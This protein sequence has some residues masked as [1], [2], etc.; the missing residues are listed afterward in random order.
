[1]PLPFNIPRPPNRSNPNQDENG[2]YDG[3]TNPYVGGYRTRGTR[4]GSSDADSDAD[5]VARSSPIPP[6]T[7][8][9]SVGVD[10]VL[11]DE[12]NDEMVNRIFHQH[13]FDDYTQ[14]KYNIEFSLLGGTQQVNT[15]VD[16]L[17]RISER[18]F[19]ASSDT[20][21]ADE[22]YGDRQPEVQFFIKSLNF[23]TINSLSIANPET[24]NTAMFNMEIE[25]PYGFS[26]DKMIRRAANDLGYSS[27]WPANRFIF[28]LD[29]WFSGYRKNGEFVERIPVI[30]PYPVIN[31]NRESQGIPPISPEL[32][33]STDYTETYT[34]SGQY[35]TEEKFTFF[36][37]V[38][39]IE[40]E[41]SNGT[42][43]NYKL[44][45]LPVQDIAMYPEYDTLNY[46][47]LGIGAQTGNNTFGEYIDEMT[48]YLNNFYEWYPSIDEGR[49]QSANPVPLRT[50]EFVIP[51]ELRN[52]TFDFL[53][54]TNNDEEAAAVTRLGSQG[55]SIRADIS[56]KI[57]FTEVGRSS[58]ISR[59]YPKEIYTVR[60]RIDYRGSTDKHMGYWGDLT[61]I[62]VV[63][64]IEKKKEYRYN[65]ENLNTRT[66]WSQS[67][68]ARAREIIASGAL[69]K[70]YKYVFSGDNTVVK[71]FDLKANV[72]WNHIRASSSDDYRFNSADI[73]INES[74]SRTAGSSYQLFSPA[75]I[76]NTITET[77]GDVNLYSDDNIF[78]ARRSM[79]AANILGYSSSANV[80]DIQSNGSLYGNSLYQE[81]LQNRLRLSSIVL[82]GLEI[83]GE[84]QWL[85]SIYSLNENQITENTNSVGIAN[86]LATDIIYL[87]LLYPDQREYMNPDSDVTRPILLSANYGGFFQIISVEHKFEGGLYN[88]SLQGHRLSQEISPGGN[89]SIK[90]DE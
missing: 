34:A 73:S 30:N 41:L 70:I 58:I 71:N 6:Q 42:S 74:E 28:R 90:T 85:A 68:V 12:A 69:K 62:K 19:I 89:T 54:E 82:E 51:D 9:I 26:L 27:T 78:P 39:Q 14:T 81:Q 46:L 86:S 76:D 13:T 2:T 38:I 29:I 47:D 24:P 84:P 80:D 32:E 21:G 7:P 52:A 43:T 56:E 23:K 45:M 33:G 55:R 66:D 53:P 65:P 61:N 57:A 22:E 77:I 49:M 67:A 59:D 15:G 16:D 11:G 18:Y 20:T 88:Q 87:K 31:V 1:M 10:G 37:H 64:Y 48:D 17:K 63:Y 83:R 35:S 44:Q 60:A 4:S 79:N 50:Y 72:F 25:E 8:Y 75:T 40:S 3:L 36:V 5:G